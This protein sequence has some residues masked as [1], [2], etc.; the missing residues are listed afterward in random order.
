[1]NNKIIKL[2]EDRGYYLHS[3][4]HN[5]EDNGEP[6][7]YFNIVNPH[8]LPVYKRIIC[9]VNKDNY[10]RFTVVINPGALVMSTGWAS[11]ID[12]QAHFD[13]IQSFLIKALKKYYRGDYE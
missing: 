9:E 12:N 5:S 3:Y 11:P 6:C 8:K 2:M 10:F 13:K 7:Y 4:Q 1:M